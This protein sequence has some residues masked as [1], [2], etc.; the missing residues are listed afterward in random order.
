EVAAVVVIVVAETGEHAV[1]GQS[2]DAAAAAAVAQQA[3]RVAGGKAEGGVERV[4]AE[5][6]A[7]AGRLLA[8]GFEVEQ[9]FNLAAALV[10]D[11]Q[12]GAVGT[13]LRLVLR[14][15]ARRRPEGDQQ[16]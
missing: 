3:E 8:G 12:D 7:G 9:C 5:M 1:A 15:H 4:A 6:P 13:G 14:M 16:G 2:A 11:R 10:P